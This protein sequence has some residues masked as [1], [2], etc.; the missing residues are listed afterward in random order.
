[1]SRLSG[2]VTLSGSAVSGATVYVVD[3]VN[4]TVAAV[5]TTDANGDWEATGLANSA[6]ERYHA[7][8]QYDDGSTKYNAE[9]LP[10]L[11]TPGLI[12]PGS[13]NLNVDSPTPSITGSAIPDSVVNR[14][15]I[16]SDGED[17]LED[18]EGTS[19]ATIVGAPNY[20]SGTWIDS[21][22]LDPDGIDD[23]ADSGATSPPSSMTMLVTIDFASDITDVQTLHTYNDAQRVLRFRGDE[24]TNRISYQ[25]I[26]D[27]GSGVY[28]AQTTVSQG[29]H[30]VAGILDTS[31]GE[32]KIAVDGTV[33]TT[34]AASDN[35]TNSHGTHGLAYDRSRNQRFFGGIIDEPMTANEAYSSQQLTDDYDRQPWSA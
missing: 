7:L 24:G 1:M 25:V 14:W 21:W 34:N 12:Q 4:D 13:V 15:P 31:A 23:G 32:V 33:Q 30:R 17:P 11:S 3:S 28:R 18:T 2:S 16:Q 9:S 10:Y 5:T 27:D 29:T 22:A 19:D 20:N 8:V 35:F 6:Q 26:S